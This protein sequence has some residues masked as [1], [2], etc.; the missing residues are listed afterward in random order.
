MQL[1][2]KFMWRC[3]HGGEEPGGGSTAFMIAPP[4]GELL[5]SSQY[6]QRKIL[7][8]KIDKAW[9]LTGQQVELMKRFK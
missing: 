1:D 3:F 7:M 4:A 9:T 6:E 8:N 5:A 2:I